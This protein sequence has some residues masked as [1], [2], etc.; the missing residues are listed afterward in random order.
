[1]FR[2][3]LKR[4][5]AGK[6]RSS[7]SRSRSSAP[8]CLEELETRLTPSA[9]VGTE[10]NVSIQITPNLFGLTVTER[11]TATVTNTTVSNPLPQMTL[12]NTPS[13]AGTVYFNLNN[14]QQQGQLDSNGQATATFTLP[15]LALFT[16]QELTAQYAGASIVTPSAISY[17]GSTFNA[18]V[19]LNFDNLIFSSTILFNSLTAQQMANTNGLPPYNTAQGEMDDFGPVAFNYSDPGLITSVEAFGRQYSASVAAQLG[20]Y[21]PEFV[22]S[23]GGDNGGGSNGGSGVNN[24]H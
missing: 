9:T 22:N 23:G 11:V 4:S 21:G 17:Q 14:Q 6:S 5:L 16:S 8:P 15:L 13:P 7:A 20:A 10:T 2:N 18:P 19:Y 24:G 3:L 1:M 12:A